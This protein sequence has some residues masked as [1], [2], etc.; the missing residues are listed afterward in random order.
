MM[1]TSSENLI[2][3]SCLL[4][5]QENP[6]HDK[7][8]QRVEC[9]CVLQCGA[10]LLKPKCKIQCKMMIFNAWLLSCK[11]QM[12]KNVRL[13][14]SFCLTAPSN[15]KELTLTSSFHQCCCSHTHYTKLSISSE[16]LFLGFS[17][18]SRALSA[19]FKEKIIIDLK[20]SNDLI[21]QVLKKPHVKFS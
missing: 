21:P 12:I 9:F 10:H 2:E 15:P 4:L 18:S 11:P 1:L 13:H 17:N 3:K 5:L 14:E 16:T 6:V 20:L 8:Q 19:L 7:R